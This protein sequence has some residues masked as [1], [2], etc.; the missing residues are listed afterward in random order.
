MWD[1]FR[2]AIGI[3]ESDVEGAELVC[4][5]D[6]EVVETSRTVVGSVTYHESGGMKV[7]TENQVTLA[8]CSRCDEEWR[9][10]PMGGSWW[11]DDS[12]KRH[13]FEELGSEDIECDEEEAG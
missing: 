6:Y 8:Q 4:E 10:S 3:D 9:P 1:W 5:H 7:T 13:F 2:E 12:R 11:V